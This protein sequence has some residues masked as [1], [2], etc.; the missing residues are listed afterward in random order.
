MVGFQEVRY[1]PG[2]IRAGS[3]VQPLRVFKPIAIVRVHRLSTVLRSVILARLFSCA[4]S[5]P[6]VCEPGL[7]PLRCGDRNRWAPH[8]R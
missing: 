8:R 4:S 5:L 3:V 1:R 7:R 6:R 2:S